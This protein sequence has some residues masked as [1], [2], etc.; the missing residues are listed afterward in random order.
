MGRFTPTKPNPTPVEPTP[1]L[2]TENDSKE[3][4][5]TPPEEILKHETPEEVD[6]GPRITLTAKK[7]RWWQRM[8]RKK[9]L[10]I[11][12]P[13]AL[14]LVGT[15]VGAYFLFIKKD[16][17]PAP[18][19]APVVEKAEEPAKPTTV[20]SKLTGVQITP[21]LNQ[22]GVTGVMIENSIDARP[23][24][25][26]LD[27]GVVYEAIAE[28]GI[29]RFL[30]LYQEGQP[31]YI[32]PVRS[33]RPYYINWLLPYNASYMHIGG[34]AEALQMI[35][36]LSLRD[37][38]ENGANNPIQRV[39][40]R[41]APHNA[42]TSMAK[43]DKVRAD[44]GWGNPDFTGLARKAEDPSKAPTATIID[45]AI[46]STSFYVH[47]DYD[48]TTNSYL[49]SEGGAAHKDEKTGKQLQP[50]VVVALII[51]YS[52]HSDGVHSNY[53]MIGGGD[54]LIFQD[55]TVVAAKWSKPQ[56]SAPLVINDAAG[57]ALPLNPGQT[58]FTALGSAAMATYKPPVVA[59]PATP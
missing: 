21:E 1:P 20:A 27:A 9:K 54:A 36:Q 38:G 33:A 47:Y 10:L 3:P 56:A 45:F 32:G 53:A 46:S 5:F 23:Q 18:K 52:V 22:R 31:D 6:T 44:R 58:W 48:A 28:G 4:V 42:Y 7:Q 16:A 30:A 40:N 59:T 14:V 43:L 41:Y 35:R 11:F 25:G 24:S 57:N 51:P 19:P 26:L 55:G 39:S 49:R 17:A 29:T 50:K 37:M 34:S 15:G 12:I 2:A 13:A 8:S